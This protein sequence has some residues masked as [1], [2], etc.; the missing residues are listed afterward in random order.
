MTPGNGKEL[1]EY[2]SPIE[3]IVKVPAT[4]VAAPTE[5]PSTKRLI[6][7]IAAVLGVEKMQ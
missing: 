4:R 5:T 1:P 3:L 7:E 2:P 6:V